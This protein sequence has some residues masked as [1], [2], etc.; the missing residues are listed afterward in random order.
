MD[1]DAISDAWTA[2]MEDR[3]ERIHDRIAA[4]APR[5][6]AYRASIT[7]RPNTPRL[8]GHVR[9]AQWGW[10]R[11]EVRSHGHTIRRGW[12]RTRWSAEGRARLTLARLR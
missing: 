11:W 9:R 6:G 10:W 12:R 5:E 1:Y 8:T 3:A 4:A 7:H 2:E